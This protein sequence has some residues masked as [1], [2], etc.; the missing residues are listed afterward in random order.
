[1]TEIERRAV[2]LDLPRSVHSD[3]LANKMLGNHRQMPPAWLVMEGHLFVCLSKKRKNVDVQNITL[4]LSYM[5]R[6]S[7]ISRNHRR[8]LTTGCIVSSS[9]PLK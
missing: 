3:A 2:P 5:V 9:T 8:D 7:S 1:M 4:L 6:S